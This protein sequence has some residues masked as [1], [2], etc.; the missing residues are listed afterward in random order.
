MS[1]KYNPQEAE[2]ASIGFKR[3]GFSP[4]CRCIV[5]ALAAAAKVEQ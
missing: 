5:P 2:N 1:I 3:R 4:R